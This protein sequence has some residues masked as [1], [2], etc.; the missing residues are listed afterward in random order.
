VLENTPPA[1]FFL[2]DKPVGMSSAGVVGF[3]KHRLKPYLGKSFKIGHGGTLDPF[4][5]GLLPIGLGKATKRL[6]PLL[7]G[8]KTYRFTLQFGTQTTT[9]DPEGEETLTSKNIPSKTEMESILPRFTGPQQQT[10]PAFSA[11]K[12]GGQRAY[13]LARKGE[14]V[15]LQPRTITIHNLSLLNYEKTYAVLE[16]TVSKGTYIRTLGED[17]A[18]AA[19]TVGHLTTLQRTAHGPFNISEAT[20]LETLDN[21]LKTG[22]WKAHLLPLDVCPAVENTPADVTTKGESK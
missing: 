14:Q 13:K 5:T 19:G 12:V 8:S 22:D 6:Q 15:T 11:L 7:E 2:I 18:K 3:I 21:A 20:S 10:P 1:G 9:G 4:A 17:M 16:A